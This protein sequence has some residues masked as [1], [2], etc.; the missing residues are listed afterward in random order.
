M[1]D[2]SLDRRPGANPGKFEDPDFT[3]K[4]KLR[5][6]VP[7]TRLQTLWF[8]TGS[9]CNI[10]CQNC[11]IESSPRN[12]RLAYLSLTEVRSYLD[13]IDRLGW[14]VEEIAFT[15]GEP[16]LNRECPAMLGEALARGYQVLVLTNAMRP[17]Q[18]R[19]E[20]LLDLRLRHGAA[21]TMR[22][23]VDHFLPE[24][25]EAVRGHGTWHP[26]LEGL[27]WLAAYGFRLHVAGRTLWHESEKEVRTGFAGLFAA[28]SIPIEADDPRSL[29]LFPEMDLT[30]EAPEITTHCWDILGKR[31]EQMMCASS[32]MVIKRKGAGCPVVVPCTLLP[33][34]PQFEVGQTLATGNTTVKL[35]H[36]FCAQFCVLGGASC[37]AK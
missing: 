11:Y 36:P 26:M 23:S 22:V 29:V 16:F 6:S 12:D 9:L 13:E 28:E 24:K 4:G 8:N 5:A 32:R 37:S 21:L 33:Y 27:R 2:T 3:A 10:T 35:N 14:P 34:D 7:L 25:H 19:K 31:P 17:M 20:Q 18:R 15:G 1:P 30:T